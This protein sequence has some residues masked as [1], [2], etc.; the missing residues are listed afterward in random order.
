MS[1]HWNCEALSHHKKWIW[2]ISFWNI[3]LESSLSID[4]ISV[5]FQFFERSVFVTV[6]WQM[7]TS[8][9]D[10]WNTFLS[11][12]ERAQPVFSGSTFAFIDKLGY[13]TNYRNSGVKNGRKIIFCFVLFFKLFVSVHSNYSLYYKI[14]IFAFGRKLC[15]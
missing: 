6:N 8:H 11:T 13:C 7:K 3:L 1:L 12:V 4:Y 14:N 15:Y 5:S 9:T 2:L 10:I